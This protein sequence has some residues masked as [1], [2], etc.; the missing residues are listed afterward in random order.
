MRKKQ[1]WIRTKD[2]INHYG[3]AKK[4]ADALGVTESA[5]S[6]YG[7]YIPDSRAWQLQNMTNDSLPMA[8]YEPV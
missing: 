5:V 4:L 3:S 2:A 1:I 8:N 7:E 6:Q